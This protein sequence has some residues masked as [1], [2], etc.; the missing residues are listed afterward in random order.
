[1]FARNVDRK[2]DLPVFRHR[3]W[4]HF[5]RYIAWSLDA[6]STMYIGVKFEFLFFFFF[7]GARKISFVIFLACGYK[8]GQSINNTETLH[9][10]TA[11][12]T[13]SHPKNWSMQEFCFPYCGFFCTE[14]SN[15]FVLYFYS[16]YM[17]IH[18]YSRMHQRMKWWM[19]STRFHFWV[20]MVMLWWK[21]LD[22]SNIESFEDEILQLP[23]SLSAWSCLPRQW[24]LA[25]KIT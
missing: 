22:C 5:Y 16:M 14:C 15:Q 13:R 21:N 2:F 19:F 23:P 11:R 20:V 7:L 10:L 4:L 12:S 6:W 18:A 17:S 25:R 9:L 1:M 8:I 24:K 3:K